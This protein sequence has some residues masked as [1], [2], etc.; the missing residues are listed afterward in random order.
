MVKILKTKSL[1]G[2]TFPRRDEEA[3]LRETVN[4][5]KVIK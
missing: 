2:A 1:P 5:G 3:I 4:R